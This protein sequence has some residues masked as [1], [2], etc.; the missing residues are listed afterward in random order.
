MFTRQLKAQCFCEGLYHWIESIER[1]ASHQNVYLL[2]DRK[3]TQSAADSKTVALALSG[4]VWRIPE[5]HPPTLAE[6]RIQRRNC[7]CPAAPGAWTPRHT[8]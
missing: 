5:R 7:R 8:D 4:T 3:L 2:A 1:S 6:G